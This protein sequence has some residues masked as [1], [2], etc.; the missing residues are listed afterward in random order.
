MQGTRVLSLVQEAPRCHG[1]T[2]STCIA[3]E[4][5]CPRA[6]AQ[7][8]EEPE[9][10]EAHVSQRGKAHAQKEDRAQPQSI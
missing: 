3:T 2:N 8:Q 1:A 4:A 10:S 5:T 7:Q 9:Q 6:C